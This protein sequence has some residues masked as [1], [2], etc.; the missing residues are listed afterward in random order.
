MTKKLCYFCVIFFI[1]FSPFIACANQK[2][3]EA[4]KARDEAETLLTEQYVANLFLQE[5]F[6][7]TLVGARGLAVAWIFAPTSPF[8]DI[9]QK[10]ICNS[11]NF[12]F[13]EN[14][15]DRCFRCVVLIHK[16]EFIKTFNQ[17]EDLFKAI[18]GT[19]MTARKLLHAIASSDQPIFSVLNFDTALLG[20]L[21]GF[22]RE[23]S[24]LFQRYARVAPKAPFLL[25]QT[26]SPLAL[27][28]QKPL[29]P[30]LFFI[31]KEICP[32]P[33]FISIEEEF[34]WL[35]AHF[36]T[37]ASKRED[38]RFYN[39]IKPCGFRARESAETTQ[40]IKKYT[41][42]KQIL[43]DLFYDRNIVDVAMR[44]LFSE[45]PINWEDYAEQN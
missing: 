44:E 25:T 36:N 4:L 32:G 37:S 23:N 28:A 35:Q 38:W 8:R 12:L 7:F 16:G 20:I 5:G 39:F 1:H 31:P 45:H 10:I 26:P 42:S 15:Q 33:N 3:T 21:L 9:P 41:L 18:L 40:L 29:R 6:G 11:K 22:G 2:S 24:L 19:D 13:K 34:G 17:N 27:V 30:K 43:Y 14:S